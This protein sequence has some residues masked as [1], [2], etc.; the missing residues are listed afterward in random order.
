MLC[1]MFYN[2]KDKTFC[3]KRGRMSRP[4]TSSCLLVTSL[5]HQGLQL[6]LIKGRGSSEAATQ[7][8]ELDSPYVAA[9][10]GMLSMAYYSGLF[11]ILCPIQ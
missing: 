5:K 7:E 8:A 9:L 4:E 3:S 1:S 6:I 2:Y 10:W 11:Q